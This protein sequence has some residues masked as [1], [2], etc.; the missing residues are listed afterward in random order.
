MLTPT[1][2]ALKA[3]QPICQGNT[4]GSEL[5]AA[6]HD[7]RTNLSYPVVAM[8]II[9]WIRTNLTGTRTHSRSSSISTRIAVISPTHRWCWWWLLVVGVCSQTRRIM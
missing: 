7:L 6:A 4:L 8:G 9:H 3:V 2:S 5:Q 1:M